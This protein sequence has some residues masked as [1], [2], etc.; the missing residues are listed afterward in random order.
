[1]LVFVRVCVEF[2]NELLLLCVY[3]CGECCMNEFCKYSIRFRLLCL[4]NFYLYS[5]V[6]LFDVFSVVCSLVCF[7]FQ[8]LIPPALLSILH[9]SLFCLC[10]HVLP[11]PFFNEESECGIKV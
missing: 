9:V 7:C 1:M 6:P 11:L 4:C 10:L 3:E 2:M 5:H 8:I